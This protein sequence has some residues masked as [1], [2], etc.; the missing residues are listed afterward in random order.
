MMPNFDA[1]AGLQTAWSGLNRLSL[2][3]TGSDIVE[4]L[5]A[6]LAVAVGYDGDHDRGMRFYRLTR[7]SQNLLNQRNTGEL[8]SGTF[9]NLMRF[10]DTIRGWF[11]DDFKAGYRSNVN[12]A[13]NEIVAQAQTMD[14]RLHQAIEGIV[15][16]HAGIDGNG[17]IAS[18]SSWAAIPD[19]ISRP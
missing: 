17:H 13:R 14:D 19:L 3:N 11:D 9:G 7:M 16:K 5:V 10:S 15:F 1:I 6:P 2:L 18:M 12:D 8:L 4:D